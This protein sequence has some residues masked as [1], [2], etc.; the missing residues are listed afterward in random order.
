M[1]MFS[2]SEQ[3]MS[4]ASLRHHFASFKS[5]CCFW[6]SRSFQE[7]FASMS[8]LFC[9]FLANFFN[10]HRCLKFLLVLQLF[11]KGIFYISLCNYH[12]KYSS[13][14]LA[15]VGL[16]DLTISLL[17]VKKMASLFCL[18]LALSKSPS[19]VEWRCLVVENH[20]PSRLMW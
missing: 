4:K 5:I 14:V 15:T 11:C 19:S 18:N 10:C 9:D 13:K 16:L 6:I 3:L 1:P 17:F 8:S 7:L 2:L 20:I 12:S